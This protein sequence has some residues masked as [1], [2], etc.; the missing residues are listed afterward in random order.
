LFQSFAQ[1]L[2][3]TQKISDDKLQ[4]RH[5]WKWSEGACVPLEVKLGDGGGRM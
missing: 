5:T 1:R 4:G 2:E 3:K